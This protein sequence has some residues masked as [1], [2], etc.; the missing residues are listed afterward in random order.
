METKSLPNNFEISPG[1]TVNDWMQLT[2]DENNYNTSDW[3]KA[4]SILETRIRSRFIEPAQFLID[5]EKEAGRGKNGF[6]ILAIDFL[7]IETI[8]GFR[9]G[10]VDHNRQSQSLFKSF[11]TQWPAYNSCVPADKDAR[12]LAGDVYLQGRCALHHTGSTDR[13]IVRKSGAMF[14]FHDDGRIEIN[15]TKLHRE[16]TSD[17]NKYLEDLKAPSSVELRYNFRKK[18]HHIC[19]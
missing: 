13:I 5:S 12:K 2:L 14:V 8:Q 16:L 9:R 11:L 7:L 10:L 17:F 3:Q 19:S 6:A 1:H 4:I 18:M 15:R